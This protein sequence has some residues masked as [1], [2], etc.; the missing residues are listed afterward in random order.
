MTT[1]LGVNLRMLRGSTLKEEFLPAG[2]K[3][4]NLCLK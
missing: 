3:I 4:F 1:A 2:E